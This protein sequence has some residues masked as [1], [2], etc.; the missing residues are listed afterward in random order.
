[1]QPDP[2]SDPEEKFDR[3][4]VSRL[5]ASDWD[6]EDDDCYNHPPGEKDDDEATAP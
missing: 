6:N 2:S 4:Y 1:M 3:E 5:W